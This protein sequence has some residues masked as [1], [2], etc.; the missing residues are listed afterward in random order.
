M[1]TYP[2]LAVAIILFTVLVMAFN[3]EPRANARFFCAYGKVFIEFEEEG[4]VWGTMWIDE[5]GRPLSCKG[6]NLIKTKEHRSVMD[7]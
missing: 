5:D 1:T 4:R 3:K 2:K 6:D 7:I